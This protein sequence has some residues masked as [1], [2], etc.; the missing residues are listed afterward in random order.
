MRT[1]SKHFPSTPTNSELVALSAFS[2]S[3]RGGGYRPLDL[4]RGSL[5]AVPFTVINWRRPTMASMLKR[6]LAEVQFD[7]VQVQSIQLASYLPILRASSSHPVLICDSHNIESEVMQRYSEHAATWFRRVY[8]GME[9]PRLRNYERRTLP[10]F[11]AHLLV[12]ARDHASLTAMCPDVRAFTVENG[13]DVNYYREASP[14][15]SDIGSNRDARFRVLFVGSMDYHSNIDAACQF[16]R[17]VWPALHAA[18]PYLRFTVV[19][20]RPSPQ[21]LALAQQPGI[22]VTGTVP[23]VRPYLREALVEVVP[24]RIGGGTRLKILEA[25]ASRVPVVATPMG[26]EGL[27]VS[28]GR[29]IL[30][31]R[32]NEEFVRAILEL[33]ANTELQKRLTHAA[34]RLVVSRHD[35]TQL[36]GRLWDVYGSLLRQRV[37][38]AVPSLSSA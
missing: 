24:L 37:S 12:S 18:S 10:K 16:A 1:E 27:Q 20:C 36:G 6:L 19:G 7:A 14:S 15:F 30:L 13:V 11:D 2:A 26:A 8:A 38:S 34:E 22:E 5:G 32:T 28:D 17:D 35:W 3:E 9:A 33:E 4:L 23:D 31:A 21:V 25:M 29:D